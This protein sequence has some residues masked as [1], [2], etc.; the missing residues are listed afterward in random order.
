[1]HRSKPAELKTPRIPTRNTDAAQVMRA[2]IPETQISLGSSLDTIRSLTDVIRLWIVLSSVSEC[3][4]R[5]SATV[6]ATSTDA[7]TVTC[8]CRTARWISSGMRGPV[9][10]LP[11][12]LKTVCMSMRYQPRQPNTRSSDLS[13]LALSTISFSISSG[14]RPAPNLSSHMSRMISIISDGS[15]PLSAG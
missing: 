15:P 10:A 14:E 9:R 11:M 7:N 2:P 12:E 3:R 6:P 1:M 8:A 13:E 4:T 5:A